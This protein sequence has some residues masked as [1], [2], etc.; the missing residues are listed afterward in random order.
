[1]VVVVVMM[2]N[3]LLTITK[4]LLATMKATTYRAVAAASTQSVAMMCVNA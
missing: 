1:M 3:K 4:M 2:V